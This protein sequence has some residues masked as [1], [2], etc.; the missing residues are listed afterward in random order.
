MSPAFI[1]GCNTNLPKAEITF[2]K[3]YVVKEVNK[4]MDELRR[5]ERKGN[6]LLK[7]HKYT[8]L[9]SKL[10]SKMKSEKDFLME[11]YPKLG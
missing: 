10:T 5:L 2:D 11:L 3:F 6:D 4:V 7:G 1:L 8:F 9:K